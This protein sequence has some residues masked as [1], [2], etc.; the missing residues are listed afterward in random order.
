MTNVFSTKALNGDEKINVAEIEQALSYLNQRQEYYKRSW[1]A[2]IF[3]DGKVAFR[4]VDSKK[5][6]K[7][8]KTCGTIED[9]KVFARDTEIAQRMGYKKVT[10]QKLAIKQNEEQLV[11]QHEAWKAKRK[12]LPNR[13]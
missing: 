10:H 11:K 8:I 1:K 9:A 3:R 5:Q 4:E 2:K 7:H 12:W 6:V 13:K